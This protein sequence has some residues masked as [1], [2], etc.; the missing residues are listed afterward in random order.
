[1]K[2]NAK[3]ITLARNIRGI[4]QGELAKA[5]NLPNQSILSNIENEKLEFE[6]EFATRLSSSLNFPLSFFYKEKSFTRLSKFY[7]RKRNAFPASELVPL[8]AKIE[9]IRTGYSEILNSVE[10]PIQKLPEIPVTDQNRPEEIARLFRLFLGLDNDPIDQIVSITER[11]GIPVLFLNVKSDKFSGLTIQTDNNA[12]LIIVNKN[13]PNDHKKFTIAH[14]LGHLIMHI[15]FTEDPDFISALENIDIVEKQADS[16]A[17]AF[18]IPKEQ[19]KYHF[20]DISYSKLDDLKLYWKVS[21][22]AILFRAREC[23]AINETRFKTL[24]IELSR[25]GER[26]NERINLSIDKPTLF[27]KIFKTFE[28]QIHYTKKQIAEEII[29]ISEA[30]FLEWFDLDQ[31]KMRV[32]LN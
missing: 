11:L 29:G 18:L 7:Y 4:S 31:P 13:M 5:L 26:K 20:R 14:E 17:G 12:P 32:V 3:R 21:K 2:L 10:I 24:F 1:M 16:F 28:D 22:Q 19:A 15:P 8:E 30:D 25:R 9:A 23:G 6:L 27:N